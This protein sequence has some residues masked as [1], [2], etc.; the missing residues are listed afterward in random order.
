MRIHSVSRKAD[1]LDATLG[2]FRLKLCKSTKL[3]RADWS[4]VLRMREED[5]PVVAYEFVEIY[6][7]GSG[8]SLEIGSSRP[9]SEA[10]NR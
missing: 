3:S 1:K 4:V 8:I 7:A 2:E 6:G 9:E 10:V 5:Y